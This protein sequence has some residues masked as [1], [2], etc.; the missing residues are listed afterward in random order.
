M[1]Y[2]PCDPCCNQNISFSSNETA[3]FSIGTLLCNILA[4]LVASPVSFAPVSAHYAFGSI[5]L[6]WTVALTNTQQKQFIRLYNSTNQ[7]LQISFDAGTNYFTLLSGATYTV[8][9]PVSTSV[10]VK[11]LVLP[12]SGELEIYAGV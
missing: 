12:A 5:T 6:G 1:A 2:D 10:S 11:S 7:P 3:R 8:E 4:A 9:W